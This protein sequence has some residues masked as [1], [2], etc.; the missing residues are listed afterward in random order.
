LLVDIDND[1]LVVDGNKYDI[2][3]PSWADLV[4]LNIRWNDIVVKWKLWFFSGEAIIPKDTFKKYIIYVAE[5]QK[6]EIK[7]AANGKELELK[8]KT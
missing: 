6:E 4:G 2:H 5:H 7:I 8:K 1:V 3:L